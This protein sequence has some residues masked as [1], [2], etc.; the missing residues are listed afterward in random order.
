MDTKRLSV[1]GLAAALGMCA[2]LAA[3]PAASATSVDSHLATPAARLCAGGGMGEN[4]V[5]CLSEP[6]PGTAVA[7]FYSAGWYVRPA[8]VFLLQDQATGGAT[9][10]SESFP[11]DPDKNYKETFDLSGQR[12]G[13]T[14]CLTLADN[15]FYDT[16][17]PGPVCEK[18]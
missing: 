7:T 11:I 10:I 5:L 17:G 8:A 3:P 6:T 1:P 2:L 4:S 18:L 13:H 14:W 12:A 9:L 15:Q 16:F